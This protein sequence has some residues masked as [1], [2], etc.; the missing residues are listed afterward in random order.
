M[1]L[2]IQSKTLP[3]DR[4][5]GVIESG[6]IH[7]RVTKIFVL[8]NPKFNERVEKKYLSVFWLILHQ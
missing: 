8:W 7:W 5:G 2:T 4:G 3:G 6:V 1:G